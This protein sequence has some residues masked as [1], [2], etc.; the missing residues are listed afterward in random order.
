M[1]ANFKND[2]I[3]ESEG[4]LRKYRIVQNDDGTVSFVDATE[5]TQI[6]TEIN[7]DT[8]NT[9]ANELTDLSKKTYIRGGNFTGN[10][11]DLYKLTDVGMYWLK[12]NE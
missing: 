9:I 2:I 7:A 11:D 3:K 8:F 6:G 1:E 5:Y 4:D 12:F 10:I